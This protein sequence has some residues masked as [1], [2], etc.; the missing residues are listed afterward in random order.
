MNLY[1]YKYVK[2]KIRVKVYD[3][4]TTYWN[5]YLLAENL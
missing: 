4:P 2:D 5:V 1:I 3:I